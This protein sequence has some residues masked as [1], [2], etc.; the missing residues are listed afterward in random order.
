MAVR[1]LIGVLC[2]AAGLASLGVGLARATTRSER[3]ALPVSEREVAAFTEGVADGFR[4]GEADELVRTLHPS[5]REL[6]GAGRCRA[7][8]ARATD[9]EYRLDAQSVRGPGRWV[10]QADG[11][12]FSVE[13]AYEVLARRTSSRGSADI[14]VHVAYF[15][16]RL[17]WF[18]DCGSPVEGTS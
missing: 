8:F 10:W 18:S 13:W 3:D 1:R 12:R 6:Y 15:D 17:V 2:V 5:V 4:T 7:I 14:A 11:R 16:G 9:R